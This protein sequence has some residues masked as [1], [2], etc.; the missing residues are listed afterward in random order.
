MHTTLNN[1]IEKI[2]LSQPSLILLFE[3][4][5][6][7]WLRYFFILSMRWLHAA[8]F[9]P[10]TFFTTFSYLHSLVSSHCSQSGDYISSV[11]SKT[12]ISIDFSFLLFVHCTRFQSCN[13]ISAHKFF[14]YR[15]LS[16]F[17]FVLLSLMQSFLFDLSFILDF[18][19]SFDGISTI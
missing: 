15:A 19:N 1:L 17:F 14:F 8:S 7:H 12:W 18:A 2:W 3:C 10:F 13:F 4:G 6:C 5:R 9:F 16:R 11:R